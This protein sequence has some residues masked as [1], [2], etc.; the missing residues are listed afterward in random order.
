MLLDRCLLARGNPAA[1]TCLLCG[2]P[3]D[4]RARRFCSRPCSDVWSIN[5]YWSAARA[6]ALA[7]HPRCEICGDPEDLEVHHRDP[8]GGNRA[9][10]CRHHVDRLVVLCHAHHAEQTRAER[11]RPGAVTQLSL[12]PA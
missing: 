3:L 1:G 5:H 4:G 6:Y 8:V 2:R 7:R 11:A 10:G 12:L 9:A